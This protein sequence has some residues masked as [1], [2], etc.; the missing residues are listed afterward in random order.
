MIRGLLLGKFMPFH[1]GH[2]A[3][4]D[5]ALQHTDQLDVLVCANAGESID[6]HTRFLWVKNY[7]AA[8][9]AV[10]VHL[11]NYHRDLLPATS[12]SSPASAQ[13]WAAWLQ[14]HY[15]GISMFIS[16]EPYGEFVAGYLGITHLCFDEKRKQVAV[17]ATAIRA[18][19]FK[20]W[21]FIPELVRP[22]FVKKIAIV[23]LESTGKSVLTARLADHYNTVFVPEAGREIVDTTQSCTLADLYTIAAMHANAIIEK[24]TIANK[25]LFADTESTITRSYG[26]YLF[27][28]TIALADWVNEANRFDLYLFLETDCPFV[29]DGTRLEVAER[30]KLN[31]SHKETFARQGILYHTITGHWQQRFE[32][33]VKLI[34]RAFFEEKA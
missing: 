14:R 4:I 1:T 7:Y 16:S 10:H 26:N 3:L 22:Y 8:N 12:E 15:P 28:E 18:Q 25:I 34:N 27:K 29:Q 24:T 5:F 6:G 33:A 9:A 23:G 19:P 31:A 20:Y 13:K 17:S 2:I 30:E 21:A 11:V 32:T